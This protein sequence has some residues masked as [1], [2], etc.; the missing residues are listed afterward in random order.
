[1]EFGQNIWFGYGPEETKKRNEKHNFFLSIKN[2]SVW[3][4]GV[5]Q[6]VKLP[7]VI[8]KGST[9]EVSVDTVD[10]FITWTINGVP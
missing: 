7:A 10:G 3:I 1:M 9:V 5:E 4:S 6:K 2:G 8:A